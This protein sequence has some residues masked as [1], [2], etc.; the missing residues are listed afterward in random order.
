MGTQYETQ[1]KDGETP[2][3]ISSLWLAVE[4]SKREGEYRVKANLICDLSRCKSCNHDE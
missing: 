1:Y 2:D 4:R 3:H